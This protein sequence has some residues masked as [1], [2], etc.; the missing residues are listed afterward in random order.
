MRLWG[1][2][3][4]VNVQKVLWALEELGL[5]YEQLN[6]GGAFGG[7]D[8]PAYLAM[9]PIRK[10]PTL[11]DGDLVIWE[12]N[13]VVR[14]LCQTYGGRL[15][16]GGDTKESGRADMWMEWFQNNPYQHF[17]ALFYQLVRLPVME[18]DTAKR[19]RA[20][21]ALTESFTILDN[22]LTDRPYMAGERFTMGD[23]PVGAALYRYYTMEFAHPN[24]PALA[25]YYDRLTQRK[26]Y[27][28]TVMTS[29]DSLRPQTE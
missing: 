12:S 18:R 3:T 16:A 19:D 11:Q 10:V 17:I 8:D 13:A 24:L 15:L 2:K 26:A 28:E 20:I 14:Y 1:R 7:L 22:H 27:Q 5:D 6:A 21:A 29:Y 25:A 23:I 9:N 4:S